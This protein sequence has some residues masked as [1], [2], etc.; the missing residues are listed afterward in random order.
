M[1]KKLCINVTEKHIVTPFVK[2]SQGSNV[3]YIGRLFISLTNL[4]CI[5]EQCVVFVSDTQYFSTLLTCKGICVDVT[6]TISW[7]RLTNRCF[8]AIL[9]F[10]IYLKS[11]NWLVINAS[12]KL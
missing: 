6:W 5:S 2:P 4:P 10:C 11:Q 9:C 3:L 1:D 8:S 12:D 7:Y